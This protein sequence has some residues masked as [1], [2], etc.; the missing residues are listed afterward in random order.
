[1]NTPACT[2]YGVCGGCT[3]QHLNVAQQHQLKQDNILQALAARA[4]TPQQLLPL[5]STATNSRRRA[6]FSLYRAGAQ[7]VCGY[8]ESRSTRIVPLSMCVVLTP[9]LQ[10]FLPH[11]Q[12]LLSPLLPDKTQLKALVTHADNN[13][14][15]INISGIKAPTGAAL[16]SFLRHCGQHSALS[17]LSVDG[18]VVY[19][20]AD[21]TIHLFNAMHAPLPAGGVFLQ[22]SEQGQELLCNAVAAALPTPLKGKLVIDLFCGLGPFT[23]VALAKGA[24]VH[25]YDN[26]KTACRALQNAT[27]ARATQITE[28]DLF[29]QPLQA[30]FLNDAAAVIINPPRAGALNQI[31]LLA[32]STVPHIVYVSCNAQTFSTD[33]AA[34][35]A[36]GYTLHTLQPIDQFIYADHIELVA[37]FSR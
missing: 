32:G 27:A 3:Q 25:G 14:I 37:H 22:P 29:K 7:V 34:L 31:K 24:R 10:Q 15:D 1:M 26:A 13:A 20:I 5:Q 6:T 4:I 2:H 18:E 12:P 23:A 30:K 33:A 36:A 19:Q 11:L 17:R 16:G 21:P 9:L 35:L 28:R 8:K